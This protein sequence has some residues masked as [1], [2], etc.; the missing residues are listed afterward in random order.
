MADEVVEIDVNIDVNTEEAGGK[1]TRLQT[2]IR[3][4][5]TA[6]Q[7]A[8]ETGDRLRF[9]Q[10]KD[11][12]DDLEDSLEKTTLGDISALANLKQEMDKKGDKK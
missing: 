3:E 7:Q 12:L 6:L 8:A 1:F 5:R 11:Q 10:L 2:Q 4:T 9:N